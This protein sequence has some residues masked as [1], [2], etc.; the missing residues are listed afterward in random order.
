MLLAQSL[1]RRHPHSQITYFVKVKLLC[2]HVIGAFWHAR[3]AQVALH[4]ICKCNI[5][6][7]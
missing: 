5:D 2:E 4:M 3:H 7:N 1:V 6:S